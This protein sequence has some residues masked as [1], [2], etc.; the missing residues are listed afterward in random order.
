MP[1]FSHFTSS[2]M[3]FG[4]SVAGDDQSSL[5]DDDDAFSSGIS[6]GC[7]FWGGGGAGFLIGGAGGNG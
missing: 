3:I 4:V 5:V 2:E 6:F 7:G 1:F